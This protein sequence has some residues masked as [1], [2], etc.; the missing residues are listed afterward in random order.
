MTTNRPLDEFDE[1][2]EL[3]AELALDKAKPDKRVKR[4]K[5]PTAKKPNPV[6]RALVPTEPS[7][8]TGVIARRLA[9]K[10]T[11][12]NQAEYEARLIAA[13]TRPGTE[14]TAYKFGT[15]PETTA[16]ERAYPGLVAAL[17]AQRRT[18]HATTDWLERFHSRLHAAT[19]A[20]WAPSNPQGFSWHEVTAQAWPQTIQA[21]QTT[22]A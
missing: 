10:F 7:R 13:A 20:T 8:G 16:A 21:T 22:Q 11:P 14:P 19:Y 18:L 4:A 3:L 15:Y 1:I 6:I 12:L 5:K 2:D 17:T 9:K